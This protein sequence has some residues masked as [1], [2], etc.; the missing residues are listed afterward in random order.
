MNMLLSSF[1]DPELDFKGMLK[2]NSGGLLS[3]ALAVTFSK[4]AEV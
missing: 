2:K 1:R 3:V 4:A